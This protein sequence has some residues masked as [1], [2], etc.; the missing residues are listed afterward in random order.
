MASSVSSVSAGFLALCE[1]CGPGGGC[2]ST[3]RKVRSIHNR[4]GCWGLTEAAPES[5]VSESRDLSVDSSV[6]RQMSGV[7]PKRGLQVM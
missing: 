7:V 5:S 1:A 2:P 3:L 6:S 4:E